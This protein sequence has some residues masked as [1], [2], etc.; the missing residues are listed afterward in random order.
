[1][2]HLRTKH[3][4]WLAAF[5]VVVSLSCAASQATNPGGAGGAGA[6]GGAGAGSP[7]C[8]PCVQGSDC[9]PDGIC[10]QFAGDSY[11]APD[12][13]QNSCAADRVCT[14]LMSTEGN[15]VNVCVPRND[16]SGQGGS[17]GSGGTTT[18]TTTTPPSDICG[19]L[20][21][22]NESACCSACNGQ[23]CQSNG[24]YGGWWCNV[25]T[26]HCQA[27]P[28]GN[29]GTG[30][31][32]AGGSDTGGNGGSVGINGGTL[33]T[34]SFAIVGDTRPNLEDDTANYPTAIIHKI[35]QDVEAASPRPAFAIS[36]GDYMFANPW[37]SEPGPQLD[38]Y[39]G[40]RAAYTNVAFPALGNHECTG[41]TASNCGAG[42]ASGVTHSYQA[43]FDKMLTPI[44]VTK[45]YYTVNIGSTTNAWSAKFV[46]MAANAWDSA[47]QSWLTTELSTPTTYTFVIRHE[48]PS[49]N[50]APGVTPSISIINQH[51]HTLTICGHTHTYERLA[52]E[53]TVIVGNGGAP[54]SG[55]VNYGYVI[56]RQRSDGAIV[57]KEYDYD[58]NAVQATFALKADGTPAP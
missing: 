8:V 4:G 7:A 49:A 41:G 57:F 6:S 53:K 48:G 34:L 46:F 19:N 24:C 26:C 9:A 18:T 39:L 21:G 30:G 1:M 32:G 40:A 3:L 29:C 20:Y 10:A 35:W 50:T 14:A 42:N 31:S 33:D 45:P 52:S 56:A 38:K 47:Q 55:S 27:A 13:S 17:G 51:P 43:F 23:P 54:L 11:C 12:C 2:H 37:G 58:T 22:P 44:G 25:D 16:C 28:S 15:Q 5:A 36:T